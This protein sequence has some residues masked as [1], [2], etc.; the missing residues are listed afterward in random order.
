M[1]ESTGMGLLRDGLKNGVRRAG[2]KDTIYTCMSMH[3]H[4]YTCCSWEGLWWLSKRQGGLD[5]LFSEIGA[6]LERNA[7]AYLFVMLLRN[8]FERTT[9]QVPRLAT[10][11]VLPEAVRFPSRENLTYYRK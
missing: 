2:C 7:K 6:T 1:G 5:G 11:G 10:F 9:H 3:V 4:M 8:V